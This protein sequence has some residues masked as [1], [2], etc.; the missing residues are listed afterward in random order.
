MSKPQ[1]TQLSQTQLNELK[2][3]LHHNKLSLDDINVVDSVIDFSIWMQ[4]E[5]E[6]NKLTI[7]RLKKL[8]GFK[9]EKKQPSNEID[10]GGDPNASEP[11][12]S[13]NA[14]PKVKESTNKTSSKWSSKENH[15][16]LS[17]AD[18]TGLQTVPIAH[19]DPF[20]AKGKCPDCAACNTKG[21]LT[22]LSP[23]MVVLLESSPLISGAKYELEQSRCTKCQKYFVASMPENLENRPKY[24]Y[25]CY[26]QIAVWHYYG[27]MPFNRLEFLQ[28]AQG[29]PLPDATQYDLM[30]SL[31]HRVGQP[32]INVL[33]QMGANAC[34]LLFDDTTGRVVEQMVEANQTNS[35][36][37]SNSNVHATA[38]LAE[39]EG[40]KICLF[41]TNTTPAGKTLKKLLQE[42]TKDTPF[43][44]MSDGLKSNFEDMED[45]LMA[46]WVIC[47]CLSHSRRKFHELLGTKNKD[48][49][50]I[51]DIMS[52]VYGNERYCKQ[53]NVGDEGRLI[54]HQKHSGPLMAALYAWLNNL[55]LHKQVE[56]NS[57]FGEAIFYLLKGWEH[58]TQFLKVPG[59]PLDNNPCEQMIKVMIRY[60]NNSRFYRTFFGA[61]M[62]DA[63][64]SIIH[65]AA[66]AQVNVFDY[67]NQLQIHEEDVQTNPSRWLPWN[68]QQTLMELEAIVA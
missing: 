34:K 52:Q 5:L 42:R 24:D 59:A 30:K 7:L 11:L 10:T 47:M 64:M 22:P 9:Q 41:D 33:R 31:Y 2:E 23:R 53:E 28:Q 40:H 67:L 50:F 4:R 8:Y 65:T 36:K 43:L 62:G 60:R 46:R 51:L 18:Y 44:T 66:L 55:I 20:L 13:E 14:N 37:K 57:R 17:A 12:A 21:N 3:R 35:E 1:V 26:T 61:S 54:Y 38:L 45:S 25:S 6:K 16:R 19:A 63:F 49:D 58:F 68:Y 29:V 56:P 15:G 48:I 32:V 39:Y 27:G